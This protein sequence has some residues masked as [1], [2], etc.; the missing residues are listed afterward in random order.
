MTARD[1][2][3]SV[4]PLQQHESRF[5]DRNLLVFVLLGLLSRSRQ[6]RRVIGRRRPDIGFSPS[7]VN[8]ERTRAPTALLLALGVVSFGRSIESQILTLAMEGRDRVS[9]RIPSGAPRRSEVMRW[10]R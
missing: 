1:R 5:K 9:A 6:A 2:L 3:R 7:S 8:A 4:G 10:L